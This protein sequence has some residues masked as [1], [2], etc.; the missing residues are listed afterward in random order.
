MSRIAVGEQQFV[1][2]DRRRTDRGGPRRVAVVDVPLDR[3][4]VPDGEAA[5]VAIDQPVALEIVV[6]DRKRPGTTLA[7]R[8]SLRAAVTST[9]VWK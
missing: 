6:V 8:R 9:L 4:P 2:G 3:S 5:D 1:R 7:E